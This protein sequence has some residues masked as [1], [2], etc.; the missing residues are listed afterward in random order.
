[1]NKIRKSLKAL[2]LIVSKPYLLNLILDENGIWEKYARNSYPGLPFL[3]QINLTDLLGSFNETIAP[4]EYL[5]GGSLPTDIG[6]LKA[7]AR[8]IPNCA[9]FE[10]GTWRGENV[11]NVS[12]VAESCITMDL[13]DAE[14]VNLGM[15]DEYISQHAAL[16]RHIPNIIHLKANS[17]TFDFN[18]L[19]KKFDLVFIDG[20]HHYKGVLN[21]TQKVFAHLIHENTVIVWHDYAFNPE[22]VRYEVFSAILDGL[23]ESHH[24]RLFHVANTLCAIYFPKPAVTNKSGNL[25][26]EV[27]VKAVG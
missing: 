13:P 12:Q 8:Q 11:A 22:K 21:D 14:K 1:M 6:L 17:L 10:I 23:P 15:T 5:D 25:S 3:K 4:Y 2:G 24:S 18:S 7:L 26:F 27:T 20:D 16:S 9:F 19:G